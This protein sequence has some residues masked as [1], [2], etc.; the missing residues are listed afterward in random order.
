MGVDRSFLEMMGSPASDIRQIAPSDLLHWKLV[1]S[2]DSVDVLA[3][4]KICTTIPAAANCRLFT[5]TDLKE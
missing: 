3:S 2:L 1:T 5:E 4:S